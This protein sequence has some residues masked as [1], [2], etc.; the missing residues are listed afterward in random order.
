MCAKAIV[1]LCAEKQIQL[2]G[3]YY[4]DCRDNIFGSAL[5]V[6]ATI[7]ALRMIDGGEENATT[8]HRAHTFTE[9]YVNAMQHLT[10][11]YHHG[12]CKCHCLSK[13]LIVIL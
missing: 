10:S 4:S 12:P 3:E 8:K 2:G 9:G 5:K 6:V 7:G 13:V 11:H 1:K